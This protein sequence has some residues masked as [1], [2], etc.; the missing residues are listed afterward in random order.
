MQPFRRTGNRKRIRTARISAAALALCL[1]VIPRDSRAE[2]SAAAAVYVRSDSDHT[3]VVSPH[4]RLRAAPQE[5]T[6]VDLEYIVDV[7]TSASVDIVA[8][9]SEAVTEE[10]DEID[11]GVDHAFGDVTLGAAYRYS[12][13]PDYESHGGS[14]SFAW[15]L[16]NKAA[17]LS[18]TAG[19]SA[20]Q[21]GRAGDDAFAED[22]RTLTA[23]AS[24]TQILDADTLV[25]VLYDLAV[26]SGYQ[27]S[28][29][30]FIAIGSDGP[31]RPAAQL[32]LPEQNP[33][34]RVRHAVAA[35]AR[36]ALSDAW[37]LGAGYRFYVDDWGI[38]SHTAKADLAW[39]PARKSTI[40][41]GYRFYR[42]SAADHYK[43]LYLQS[44]LP[45]AYY[46]RDKELS[47]LTSHRLGL[48]LDVVW[49]LSEPGAGLL[50]ALEVA[51]TFYQYDDFRTLSSITALEVTAVLGMEFE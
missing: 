48:E 19:G 1:C 51:P 15:D 27:S 33:R 24:F 31:C 21:V 22:V 23:G 50:T 12:T 13:E 49:P 46:T 37:S 3:T 25:Q 2:H 38:L 28:A 20:D 34:T 5:E 44:D 11:V 26:V 18:L 30:R 39:A 17:T 47:P 4:L 43:A 14:L 42:Q 40:A 32:C 45:A 10:R 8:S 7:W 29:Y 35:R 36:R 9:A 16:A 41:L 6:H